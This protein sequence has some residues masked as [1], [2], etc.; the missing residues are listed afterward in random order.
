MQTTTVLVDSDQVFVL[1]VLGL[2]VK[3]M[4]MA[5]LMRLRVYMA[6]LMI[7]LA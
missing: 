5:Y 6:Y 7:R 2:R 3:V 4:G 1:S